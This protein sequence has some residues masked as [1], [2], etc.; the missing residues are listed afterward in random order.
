MKEVKFLLIV[1]LQKLN[2]SGINMNTIEVPT[3]VT[4]TGRTMVALYTVDVLLLTFA[5]CFHTCLLSA[6]Q[7]SPVQSKDHRIF[8][9]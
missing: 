5:L 6:L 9:A 7:F 4:S 2:N 3:G 8:V 1:T